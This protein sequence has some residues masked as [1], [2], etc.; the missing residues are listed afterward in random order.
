ILAAWALGGVVALLG[1][2]CFAE[3]GARRP[4]AGGGY[5]Y[6]RET[7]GPLPAF[8]YGW[9]LLLVI[10]S[11]GI[12]AVGMTF[13]SYAADLAGVRAERV[14]RIGIAAIAVLTVINYVGIWPGAT[15]Q[16][17]FTVLKLVALGGLI[18][19]GLTLATRGTEASGAT[20]AP[21]PALH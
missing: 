16:N 3:L 4:E 13:A 7:L 5:V 12:A 15:T 10:N 14:K 21:G 1:A 20:E 19:A 11:G 8:L 9:T 2:L 18:L 17:I 6:L